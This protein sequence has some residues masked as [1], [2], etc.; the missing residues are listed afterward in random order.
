MCSDPMCSNR[1]RIKRHVLTIVTHSAESENLRTTLREYLGGVTLLICTS[2]CV[3][4]KCTL[5]M[6]CLVY[7]QGHV[8]SA[9]S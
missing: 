6:S 4:G 1:A 9:D 8:A 2:H 3:S 7:H 5:G